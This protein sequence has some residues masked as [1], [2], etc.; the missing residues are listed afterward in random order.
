MPFLLFLIGA[1][2]LLTIVSGVYV[3]VIGC[4]RKKE[5]S[6]LIEEEIRKTS[7][8]KYYEHILL[9]NQ[10]LIDH[11]ATDVYIKSHDGLKL[12]GLWVPS[13]NPRGT[14]LFAHGYRST[15]LVDF[16][17]AF[18][19]YHKYRMNLLIPDQR[20]HGKSEGKFITFGVKESKDMLNWIDFHNERFGKLP[21]ILSG[22]SMGASTMM[23]L[24]DRELPKNVKG[25]IADCGF[26][27]PK[28]ILASVFAKVIR[29]PA[30]PT[31]FVTDILARLIAGF[32]ITE[33]DTRKV[34]SKNRL[35]IIMIHGMD[36]DFVPCSMTEEAFAVCTGPKQLLLVDGADH[37]VSFLVEPKRYTTMVLD[38]LD[39]YVGN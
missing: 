31:L 33:R 15:L 12:H 17:L 4:V 19:L 35:P 5:I 7:Y 27:S 37:G 6:W 25:I 8:G 9:A 24:A 3:F 26:T 32:S 20:S 14:V 30:V 1:L 28:E 21:M 36:D 34:L 38:F 13:E 29:L 2:I 11:K 23:Y 39:K 22:L 18:E 16:G 10:W